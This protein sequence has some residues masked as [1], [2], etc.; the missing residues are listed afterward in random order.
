MARSVKALGN[1]K[2]IITLYHEPENDVSGGAFGCPPTTYKGHAGTPAQYVAMWANVQSRF[3]AL[4][5]TNVVWSMDYIGYSRW[6]CMVDDLWP[7]NS[8]V[9]WVLWDPYESSSQTFS[10]S[11]SGFYDELTSLS[12][13]THDYLALPWGLGEFGDN[14]SS[15]ANQESFYS[16]VGQT[17]ESGQFPKLKMLVLW[18]SGS[19]R[20]AYNA[21]G[22]KD[23]TELANLAVL[24]RDPMIAAGRASAAAGVK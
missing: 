3:A 19:Y 10:D 11:V 18:D 12:D 7:G 13:A 6:N 2:I 24:S 17:L 14:S 21:A 20:V 9:D 16:S 23:P 8:R 15:N 5:V 22:A 1:T 4:G